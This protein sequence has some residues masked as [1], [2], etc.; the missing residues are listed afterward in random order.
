MSKENSNNQQ[1]NNTKQPSKNVNNQSTSINRRGRDTSNHKIKKHKPN[2]KKT[3]I[4]TSRQNNET[5]NN[6][7]NSANELKGNENLKGGLNI[8]RKAANGNIIGAT[9]S[10]LKFK[11]NKKVR[12]KRIRNTIIQMLAPIILVGS[13]FAI[14]GS[15]F[16]TVKEVITGVIES[17]I[18]VF[19]GDV[20]DK[21]IEVTDEQVDTIINSIEDLGVST[22]DLKLLGDYDEN[23]T[24]EEKQEELR[25]YIREFYKA[26]LV[27]ETLN[28]HHK[29]NTDTDTYGAVY[30]YRY[31]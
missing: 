15:V 12:N 16:D 11:G 2:K 30:I 9:K 27:T 24:D 1:G 18:D 31:R 7:Q 19:D 25:K 10:A 6:E 8:A 28:Y 23:A 26:Q 20:T 22:E 21:P 5:K 17:I 13:I 29:E 14:F 4:Y 3:R